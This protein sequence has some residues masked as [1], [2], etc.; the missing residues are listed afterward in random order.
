LLEEQLFALETALQQ[1][2]YWHQGRLV[3]EATAVAE[4]VW[5]EVFRDPP[6]PDLALA[7]PGNTPKR[8]EELIA[9]AEANSPLFA[10]ADR[11]LEMLERLA[12]RL[13][14]GH[15]VAASPAK[16]FEVVLETHEGPKTADRGDRGQ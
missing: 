15:Q 5:P 16:H 8:L 9:R 13:K 6:G 3:L 12:A 2:G 4:A 7:A 10:T 11:D 1:H 14:P